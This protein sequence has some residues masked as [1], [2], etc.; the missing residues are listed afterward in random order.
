MHALSVDQGRLSRSVRLVVAE[1]SYLVREALAEVLSRAGNV[2]V[3][4]TCGDFDSLVNTVSVEAPDAVLTDIRMPPTRTDEGIQ[5]ARSLRETNPRIG[6]V[7]LSQFVDPGYVMRLLEGGAS[8]R[9]YL[10]KQRMA[11]R[12]QLLSAIAA[13]VSGESLVD[14]D[15]VDVLVQARAREA[16]SPLG[17]LTAPERDVLAEIAQGKSNAAIAASLLLTK[18]AV[19]RHVNAIFTKLELGNAEDVSRRVKAALMFLSREERQ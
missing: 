7:V 15:V 13:V 12:E 14:P 9:A 19:E 16:E 6:V 11:D 8:G 1:D 5:V 3:V 2:E 17:R 10:L 4:G 18:R